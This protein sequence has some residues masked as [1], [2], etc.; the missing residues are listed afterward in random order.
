MLVHRSTRVEDSGSYDAP[1][2]GYSETELRGSSVSL[3]ILGTPKLNSK[4][5]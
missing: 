5:E 2:V 1:E 3:F 4:T